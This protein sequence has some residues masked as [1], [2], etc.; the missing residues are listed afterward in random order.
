MLGA[1]F[2]G[3]GDFRMKEFVEVGYL[4]VPVAVSFSYAVKFLL[5]LG[6]EVIVEDIREMLGEEFVDNDS[7]IGGDEFPFFCSGIL[8]FDVRGELAV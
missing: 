8:A 5:H 6:C 2:V 7:G 4:I 3:F 1:H